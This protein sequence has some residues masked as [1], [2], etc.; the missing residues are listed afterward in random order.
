MGASQP[1][2]KSAFDPAHCSRHEARYWPP[3]RAGRRSADR[4]AA[5]LRV[6]LGP[7]VAAW[8]A[9]GCLT[10]E[11]PP[12]KA[13]IL[14]QVEPRTTQSY[15]LYVPSRYTE[16][17][18]WPL[19]ILC[20]GTWPYD[21]A[22][23]QIREWA[24]FCEDNGIIVAAPTLLGAKGDFPPPPEK[25]LALQQQD[26]RAILGVVAALKQRYRIAEEQVFMTGWSAGAYSILYTGL[27]NSDVFRALAIRQGSFDARFM[28]VSP[29][30]LDPWQPIKV[31]Y[32]TTDPLREEALACI[33]WLREKKLYVAAEEI[34]GTHRRISPSVVWRYFKEVMRERLWVRIRAR[35]V[36][37]ADPLTVRFELDAVPPVTRQRWFFSET[38]DTTEARPVRTF[39]RP[40]KYTVSVNVAL[41]NRKSYTRTRTIEIGPQPR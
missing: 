38:D 33:A 36:D 31:I 3:H 10:L 37:E 20:H 27:R 2:S 7:L 15:L 29:E 6:L 1:R 28:D 39:P 4:A 18:P 25:Q 21:T 22:Q 19:L 34:S 26:E 8:S 32:G 5:T 30:R 41:K 9:A 13:P 11:P 24:V 14:E 17:R 23:H 40:G 16:Q 35:P 12:T